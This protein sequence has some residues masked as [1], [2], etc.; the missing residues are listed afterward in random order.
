[1]FERTRIICFTASIDSNQ[2]SKHAK[3]VGF[4]SS[5]QELD[6]FIEIMEKIAE[7]A[8]RFL[9]EQ[10]LHAVIDR[11]PEAPVRHPAQARVVDL[12]A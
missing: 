10:L 4:Y 2:N 12:T 8:I 1:M 9:A 7:E 3:W 6:A 5:S 11:R